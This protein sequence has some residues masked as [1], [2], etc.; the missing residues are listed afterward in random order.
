[1]ARLAAPVKLV[2]WD[3]DDTFWQ[4]TLSEGP[5]T[6]DP[7]RADLVR[8]LNRRGIVNAI[9]SKN[10]LDPVRRELESHGLWDEFVFVRADWT[11]KGPRVAQI[12]ED[13]QLRPENVLFVDDHPMNLGEAAHFAPG[14]QTSGPEILDGLLDHPEVA[15]KD[16][17]GLSRLAQYRVLERKVADRAAAGP[18]A[19]DGGA[20]DANTA[21]LRSCDIRVVLGRDVAAQAERLH[22]LSLRTNQLNFTKRRLDRAAFDALVADPDVESGYVEVRDRYGEYGIC[23]FYALER[24]TDTL[25]DFLFSCRAMNMGVE[26]WLYAR[27]GRP[28][29]EVVGEV[30]A[31]L[32]GEVDWIT[33]EERA[34][35]VTGAPTAGRPAGTP[36]RSG[37]ILIVGGCDLSTTADFLGGDIATEFA[38]PGPTGAFVHAGHTETLRLSARGLDEA[39][40]AVVDRVPVVDRET[41]RSAVVVD[42]SYD[43]LVL[44]VLTDYTQGLYHHRATGLVVPWQQHTFDVTDPAN[45]ERVLKRYRREDMDEA[46]FDRF[47]DEFE[48]LGGLSP[49][50]FQENIAW[51]A[52]AIPAGASL[53]LVNGAEVALDNPKEP[54]RHLHHRTMNAA[55]DEVVAD[56][57]NARVCDVRTFIT[58]HEDFTEHLR[59]YRRQCYL[60]MAEEIRTAGAALEVRPEP[61]TQRAYTSAYRF[62]GRRKLA[63]S[64]WARRSGL[65]RP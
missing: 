3:L 8:T 35:G 42:P 46:W 55:L 43:V 40:L 23:G 60:Q 51:L 33:V 4:G 54:E 19:G 39:Q 41:Y 28:A 16:D 25:V 48:F 45:R 12:I 52:G 14:L 64:R 63:I 24:T 49:E 47:A 38:H 56:L 5:V 20:E 61:W 30:A 15:G 11:S 53:I 37:R 36:G 62:A 26:Q 65:V 27:L 29:L 13:A 57:P 10:D 1:M 58:S 7:A 44:S 32:D 34:P 50:R 59:H 6:L 31:D 22:E 9:C 21:F 18:G 2:V 17:A